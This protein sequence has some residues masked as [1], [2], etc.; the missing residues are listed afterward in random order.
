MARQISEIQQQMLDNIAADS[1]LSTLLTSTSK[2]AIFRLFT[3]IVAVAINA[4]EQLIDIF[5]ADVEAVAAAAAPATPAWLQAQVFKFQYSATNPQVIQLIDF[6]PA[7]PTVDETLRIITRCSVTTNL[8]NSVI[9]KVA[10]GE[11]PA[12]LS[13]PQL[14]ALQGYVA[15]IGI[16]GVVYSVISQQPD[17]LYVQAN[18][19][20]QGQY[21]AVIKA[22]V[23]QAIENFLASIPFNGQVKI[24]DIEDAITAVEGV[25][26]VVL[27]NVL[28]RADGTAFASGSYLVQNQQT[29]SR[30]WGTVAGYMIGE[31]TTGSTLNDSLTFIAE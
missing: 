21:S 28:A 5:T 14:A 26:D 8:S 30:L 2:R 3:Y 7:Y 11:P 23:V 25:T 12:A 31:T 9:L 13:S 22:D 6:A 17:K 19:Y 18:V 4:L 15:Q 27:V 20:Y 10:T 24:T 16:A 1:V 29:V